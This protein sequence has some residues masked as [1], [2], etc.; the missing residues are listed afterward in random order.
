[1]K[2]KF[3]GIIFLTQILAL[4]LTTR[5]RDEFVLSFAVV[6]VF[7]VSTVFCYIVAMVFKLGMVLLTFSCA[8][9]SYPDADFS[10]LP[11]KC[12]VIFSPAIHLIQFHKFIQIIFCVLFFVN[13]VCGGCRC[14]CCYCH[15]L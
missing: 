15:F 13:F 12:S 8:S 9:S 5:Q 2:H 7:S 10:C 3:I 14:C 11:S 6:F 1:M 4:Q